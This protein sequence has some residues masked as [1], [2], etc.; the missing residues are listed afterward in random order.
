MP[1]KIQINENKTLKLTNVLIREIH[2]TELMDSN[3]FLVMMNNYILSKGTI[4]KGPLVQFTSVST[5]ENGQ[6]AIITK[7]ML[8]LQSDINI[9]L[10]Y[11]Y[12]S[13][14][15]QE[16]CLFARFEER[17][18]YLHLAYDKLIVYAFENDI[19]LCGNNYTVYV[20]RKENNYITA[21]I[22]M[23]IKR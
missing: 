11:V 19:S 3:R 20:E 23:P 15:K 1:E 9:E 21:D 22:F 2:E 16:N 4:S 17:E 13:M 14:I 8:Q 18:E 5:N 6:P 10:P 7:L 12:K